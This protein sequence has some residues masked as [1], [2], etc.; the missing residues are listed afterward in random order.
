MTSQNA[1]A[2]VDPPSEAGRIGDWIKTVTGRKFYPLDPRFQEV[3]IEDV[4]HALS[5]KV[6][7]NGH[8]QRYYSVAQH[9]VHVSRILERWH[10]KR[11]DLAMW[12]LL[13]DAAEAYLADIPRPMKPYTF[14]DAGD[15]RCEAFSATEN[16]IMWEI[17][18][19]LWP[20]RGP[21]VRSMEPD[22]PIGFPWPE[23]P[24]IKVA[25]NA[26]LM[27]E[28]R[29]VCGEPNARQTWRGFADVPNSGVDPEFVSIDLAKAKFLDRYEVL[30]R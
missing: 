7:F 6:R 29:M 8:V 20:V 15:S 4:A 14:H 21:L 23:P 27:D 30:A 17:L 3:N 24:E 13:H 10:P 9:S 16:R 19:K 18:L 5:M 12:G 26:A 22:S 28:A 2:S 25:D 11:R 1:Q